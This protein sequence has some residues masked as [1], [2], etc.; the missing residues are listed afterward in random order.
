MVGSETI[1]CTWGDYPCP[2]YHSR[3]GQ[4]MKPSWHQLRMRTSVSEVPASTS[5]QQ[6]YSVL[7]TAPCSGEGE[8]GKPIVLHWIEPDSSELQEL[9][10]YTQALGSR[11][12]FLQSFARLQ[13]CSTAKVA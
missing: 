2:A 12:A 11:V 3:E 4:S 7:L 10:N 1:D 6:C 8:V 9:R 5:A 13:A